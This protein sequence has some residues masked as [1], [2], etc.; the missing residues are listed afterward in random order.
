MPAAVLSFVLLVA[1]MLTNG[2]YG[3]FR[4]ELYL[5]ACGDH[6]SWGFV[7]HAPF[8]PFVAK[9]TRSVL[10]DSL[11]AVRFPS[12]LASALLVLLTGFLTRELGGRFFAITLACLT[13]IFAPVYLVEGTLFSM[14]IL[15]PLFWM[16]CAYVLI[17]ALN[18]GNPKLLIWTGV[19]AGIGLE[20]KHSM[21]FFASALVGGV[22]LSKDRKLLFTRW[23]L[24]AAAIAFVLFL[25]NLIWQIQHHYPELEALSN[26]KR[27]HKNIELSPPAFL[28]QQMLIMN[29]VNVLVWIPGLWFLF[30]GAAG[31]YRSL[32]WT[33]VILLAMMMAMHGKDY[34]LAPAYPMLLAAGA[35]F[36]EQATQIRMRWLR[37]AVAAL[38]IVVGCI[39]APLS[40]PIL[41]VE[42]L[43]RY[44]NALGFHPPRTE[45]GH[46][47][48]L[49]QYYGDM[50][51]WPEMVEKIAS[52]YN[53]LPPADRQKAAIYTGNYGEAAAVDLLGGRYGLPKAISAHETYS[54]WGPRDYTGEVII[55]VGDHDS[56]SAR[57]NCQSVDLGP[58]VGHPY[59]MAEENFQ[60]LTCRGLKTPLQE[61]WPALKHWN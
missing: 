52:V 56:S 4:D 38:V 44:Q 9:L 35:V 43:I 1:H 47:G 24:F 14:N 36:W 27:Q 40:M 2:Q 15:E 3:Y 48:K 41:P 55:V 19:L 28:A 61:M 34:Y 60:I 50:F 53:A 58:Q 49:P 20:N 7:D 18:R 30:R 6:L 59:A 21:V 11:H 46:R 26:A 10:G 25:P 31:R 22:L 45:R 57:E 17:L 23:A 37:Y 8:T 13:V 16:G 54:M 51:G 42:A 29:P 12:A 33:Y 32:A 5:L 39:A